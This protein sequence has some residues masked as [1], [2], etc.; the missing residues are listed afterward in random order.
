MEDMLENSQ[1]HFEI[2]YTFRLEPII[3]VRSL[4]QHVAKA[5]SSSWQ[6]ERQ[7]IGLKN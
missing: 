6:V 1:K 5:I 7:A 4:L 2:S 3:S